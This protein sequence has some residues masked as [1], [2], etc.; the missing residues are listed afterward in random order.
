[1]VV[2]SKANRYMTQFEQY[3]LCRQLSMTIQ[4][5]W[6]TLIAESVARHFDMSPQQPMPAQLVKA[7]GTGN[8]WTL[9]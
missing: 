3:D 7:F 1:M 9:S 5:R 4:D 8:N 6:I 2:N